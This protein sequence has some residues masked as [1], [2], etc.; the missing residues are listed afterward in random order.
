MAP[1]AF[2]V[3]GFK[4]DGDTLW[5]TQQKN[6]SGPFASPATFKLVRVE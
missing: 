4:Q 1:G 5:L 6:Q 3:Y 2:I